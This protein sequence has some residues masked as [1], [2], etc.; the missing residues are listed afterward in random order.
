MISQL[1]KKFVLLHHNEQNEAIFYACHGCAL[2]EIKGSLYF[3][4]GKCNEQTEES[5]FF[6]NFA[7]RFIEIEDNKSLWKEYFRENRLYKLG[8]NQFN[9]LKVN[10]SAF[11]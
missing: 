4:G 1:Q 10:F 7:S 6:F 11:I 2:H 8:E 3:F 5:I 9:V